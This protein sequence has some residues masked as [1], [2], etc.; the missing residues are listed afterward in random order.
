MPIPKDLVPATV[1]EAAD[2]ARATLPGENRELRF[3]FQFQDEQGAAGGRGR[4]R[5][6]LPDSLRFD[7]QG[8]LGSYH[9]AAFVI[10]DTAIWA[11]PEDEVKKLVPNYPLFWAMLGIARA[12]G[13]ESTVRKLAGGTITAWQ[14]V[15][16]GDTLEYVR[17]LAAGGRLI[18]EVRQGGK[19]LGR[20]ET[21]FGPDGLPATSRLTVSSRPARLNLTFIQ[22]E[23]ARPFAS[24]TWT[25]PAPDQR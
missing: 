9:A 12:P 17:E 8:P 14:I 5:F 24:D 20:V 25:R 10:G 13:P 22:N 4:A 3:R 11:E 1:E 7:I 2:W 16:G 19:R 21:K 23:K 15:L 6:A 18:A